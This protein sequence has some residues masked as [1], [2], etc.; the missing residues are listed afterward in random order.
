VKNDGCRNKNTE[1]PIAI[2]AMIIAEILTPKSVFL[3]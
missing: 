2:G 1:S 3:I